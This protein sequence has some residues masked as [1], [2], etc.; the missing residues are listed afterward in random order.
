MDICAITPTDKKFFS[1]FLRQEA[2]EAEKKVWELL[3]NRKYRKIKFR[4]QRVVGEYIIDFYSSEYKLGIEIDGSIHKERKEYDADRQ[5]EIESRG[6]QLIR[7]T[8]KE[9]FSNINILYQR[10]DQVFQQLNKQSS[11]SSPVS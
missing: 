9:I 1:R 11:Y 10:I 4:R 5:Q 2:T 7:V 6:I 3:R 8:N